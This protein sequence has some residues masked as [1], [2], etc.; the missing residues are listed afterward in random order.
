MAILQE[1]LF[2]NINYYISKNNF[3]NFVLDTNIM[4][5]IN[6][7]RTID[8]EIAHTELKTIKNVF[9]KFKIRF[10]L[11]HGTCL[12]AIREK[13]FIDYDSDIDIGCYKIDLDKIIL[14]IQELKEKY[15]FKITKLSLDDESITIIKDNVVIDISL[16]KLEGNIWSANR[17]KV[18]IIPYH[19]LDKLEE[20]DFLG[21]KIKVPYNVERYLEYQYGKDWRIPI[22]D[23]YS[24]YRQKIELPI[25]N[26]L[27]YIVGIKM[28]SYIAKNISIIIK[29]IR[30]S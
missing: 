19:F 22:K 25:K 11:T 28:A 15:S 20:I 23:F 8:K 7:P 30:K 13:D 9:D 27:K 21:I 2:R 26:I 1:Q 18:F 3:G 10:F 5:N 24:S 4:N 6:I 16:Y 12:G 14:A 29:K 17:H